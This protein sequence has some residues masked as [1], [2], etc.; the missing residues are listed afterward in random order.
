MSRQVPATLMS[1]AKRLCNDWREERHTF[2]IVRKKISHIGS[3]GQSATCF[4]T[5]VK[6]A[7]VFSFPLPDVLH[8][9]PRALFY[10]G[11]LPAAIGSELNTQI[12]IF[13]G[14]LVAT[15]ILDYKIK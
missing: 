3:G 11:F 10:A 2:E 15:L 7:D 13:F 9:F 4:L 8:S 6:N 12:F 5:V 1:F 14:F